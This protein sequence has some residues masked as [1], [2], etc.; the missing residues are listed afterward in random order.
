MTNDCSDV[1]NCDNPHKPLFSE[2]V[3]WILNVV[4]ARI[5]GIIFLNS[6][7]QKIF[8][9][10]NFLSIVYGYEIATPFQGYAI[11][12]I[13]PWLELSLGLFLISG[14]FKLTTWLL[15]AIMFAVFVC[16]RLYVL[17]SGLVIP[18]GCYG[19][20]EDVV[21]WQN[22]GATMLLFIIAVIAF[23]K[24]LSSNLHKRIT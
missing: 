18:C 13:V 21:N 8:L 24:T 20:G 11:A 12:L 9:P 15:T 17:W 3:A 16:A 5:V 4:V 23:Y 2:N 22:T 19:L 10:Y 6:G 14:R 1:N 7:F